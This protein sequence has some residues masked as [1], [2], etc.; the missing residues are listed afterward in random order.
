MGQIDFP[1]SLHGSQRPH[2]IAGVQLDRF[3]QQN[4]ARRVGCT[5]WPRITKK[6]QV[7]V[8][9]NVEQ[10]TGKL[11]KAEE[12]NLEIVPERDFWQGVGLSLDLLQ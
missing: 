1:I 10:E 11:L 2:A 3:S 12:Y 5:T 7:C 8:A 9:S 6:V 4:L